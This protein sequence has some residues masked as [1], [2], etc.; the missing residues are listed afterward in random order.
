MRKRFGDLGAA[1]ETI[2]KETFGYYRDFQFEIHPHGYIFKTNYYSTERALFEGI[3]TWIA[4]GGK[5][6]Y[7]SLKT[8]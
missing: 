1:F 8:K 4:N 7:N 2:K 6:I 5:Y 3:D